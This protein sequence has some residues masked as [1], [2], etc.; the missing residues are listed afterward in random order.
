MGMLDEFLD[1]V[2]AIRKE[3]N[4]TKKEVTASFSGMT[5]DYNKFK[6]QA[7]QTVN[8]IKGEAT[9][10]KQDIQKSLSLEPEKPQKPQPKPDLKTGP[11]KPKNIDGIQ[12]PKINQS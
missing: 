5:D 9:K 7:N 2:K 8:D 6:Q 4:D 3:L 12:P 10:A 1:D 11:P